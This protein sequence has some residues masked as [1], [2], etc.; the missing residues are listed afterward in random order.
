MSV[1]KGIFGLGT[2]ML[3][4]LAMQACAT[5]VV[6]PDAEDEDSGTLQP[7]DATTDRNAPP[8]PKDAGRDSAQPPTDSGRDSA[9]PTDAAIDS[10]DAGGDRP[11][12]PFDPTA[13]KPG[14]PCP[15][16]VAVNDVV[17]RRCGKCG[18]QNA[19]CETGRVVSA[20]GVCANEKTNADA[21]LPGART[22]QGCGI[23]GRQTV[24]CDNTCVQTAG[25]CQGEVP[26][27]C[28]AGSVKFLA[29]C[30]NPNEFR[31]QTCSATCAP[32]TPEP[33]APRGADVTIAV[34]QTAGGMVTGTLTPDTTAKIPALAS[35][36]C[37]TT[38]STTIS[39]IYGYVLLTNPGAQPVN[40]TV[41]NKSL[42][43]DAAITSYP[44]TTLPGDRLACEDHVNINKFTVGIA[45][46]GS[47]LVFVGGL[48]AAAAG[49]YPLEIRTNFVGAEVPGA[50]DY[51]IA[52]SPTMGGIVNQAL[53]FDE[54]KFAPLVA[55][56]N[57]PA[58]YTGA[59]P[60]PVVKMGFEYPHRYVKID[61]AG[62]TART[63]NLVTTSA[64]DDTYFSVFNAV[65]TFA[66]RR[67]CIG[68]YNDDC[69][70]ADLNA[71]LNGVSI[72]ANGSIVVDIGQYT[73]D[74][75]Y[76]TNNLRITT[77]N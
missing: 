72:P 31:K 10:G 64:G 15:A 43:T 20:Y 58:D 66:T 25:I 61:N 76:D 34:S 2:V 77:T 29:T 32:G 57:A 71:C 12:D 5:D 42:T 4:L 50:P 33:C 36:F 6:V 51:T 28:V 69:T 23:C 62:G 16:G 74:G 14:D 60:C 38:L 46:G 63:V 22:S 13:P 26:G 67:A 49:P 40:V 7:V 11:G 47:K 48:E 35:P 65:P 37:N 41:T 70:A 75:L 59:H 3:G 19:L 54:A 27:G 52:I 9:T 45:A 73:E 17:S 55:G 39:S 18:I 68:N 1:G 53:T 30:T 44:G 8:T 56:L 21:C 24:I